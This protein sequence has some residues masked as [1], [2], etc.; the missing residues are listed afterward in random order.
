MEIKFKSK[1]IIKS[2]IMSSLRVFSAIIAAA[3]GAQ[4]APLS[5]S[6]AC[7]SYKDE[8]CSSY[9]AAAQL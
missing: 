4:A 2:N 1:T 6:F 8:C 7:S 5:V 9:L 3:T